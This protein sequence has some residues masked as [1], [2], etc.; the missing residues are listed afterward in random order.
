[1][2]LEQTKYVPAEQK[3]DRYEDVN[4]RNISLSGIYCDTENAL[5]IIGCCQNIEGLTLR[6][7]VIRRKAS[8]NLYLKG[9]VFDVEP[10][11]EKYEVPKGCDLYIENVRDVSITGIQMEGRIVLE[12]VD[13]LRQAAY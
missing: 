1:M 6:D 5:G 7:I 11:S 8:K 2:A 12:R 13:G 3:P 4:I 10:C 9:E